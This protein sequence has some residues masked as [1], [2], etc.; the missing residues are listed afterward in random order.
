MIWSRTDKLFN[1]V[2]VFFLVLWITTV[3]VLL[4]ACTGN[5]EEFQKGVC[6]ATWEKEQ[7]ASKGSE[8]ALEKL[9]DMG[10]E[11]V[12]INVT[13]YQA[14]YN[15]TKVFATKRTPSDRSIKHAISDAKK[16]GMHVM[17][18]P[19]IDL[20]DSSGGTW[21]ADIGFQ[22]DK[23]WDKWFKNYEKFILHFA[24]IAERENVEIFSVGTELSFT[25]Q[26]KQKWLTIIEKI[27]E[28]YSGK[29]IYAANW[30]N[31][32][33]IQFWNELDYIGIDAYF[34]L[35]Y[36]TNPDLE[37]LV[38]GWNKWIN[39]IEQWLKAEYSTMPVIFTEIGYPS[40]NHAAREPW[41]STARGN[42]NLG[43][44]SKCYEAFF[45]AVYDKDWLEGAYWW[46]Y[47]PSIYGGGKNN[48]RFTPYQKTAEE[49]LSRNYLMKRKI[50]SSLKIKENNEMYKM[51]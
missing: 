4:L 18:K 13:Y 7:F 30:D 20:I 10:V 47:A 40:A 42:A 19:H 44:Q 24:K 6:Y 43:I 25:S 16:L 39:E 38:D 33:N 17:L 31:Y 23:D 45:D 8:Q 35:S 34:P 26:K 14:A 29:I 9:S 36:E 12:Q 48:R 49:V 27:R 1:A 2:V 37:E 3:A 46:R 28:V 11:Y 22:S 32:K 15:T 41:S 5:A 51:Q 21:R 50:G